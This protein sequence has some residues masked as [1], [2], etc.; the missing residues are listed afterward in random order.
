MAAR[1]AGAV[2]LA[3]LPVLGLALWRRRWFCRFACPAGF[4]Q[5]LLSGRRA[6]S[7]RRWPPIGAWIL[8]IT[9]GGAAF[10]YPIFLWLDP[11]AIFSGFLNAWRPPLALS[12]A[13]LLPAILAFNALLPGVWC[14]RICPLG[15]AQD[16]LALGWRFRRRPMDAHAGPRLARRAFFGVCAGGAGA[17]LTRRAAGTPPL[18]P[19]GAL[20]EDRFRGVCVRCGNCAAACPPRIIRPD[21]TNLTGFLAPSLDFA[22]DYCWETCNACGRACPSG[23]IARMPLAQKRAWSIGVAAV[24]IVTC[25]LANGQECTAC[26][27]A[28]PN[29]AIAV[30]AAEDGFESRPQVDVDRCN[31]C[32]ACEAACTRIWSRSSI[33]VLMATDDRPRRQG[34]S[35]SSLR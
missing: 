21:L 25:A 19:P 8:A 12:A 4:L 26:I 31:G 27:R 11:L 14:R 17:M 3:G 32:G 33:R 10:G 29:E 30:T 18:R 5:D 22:R 1:T 7:W 23:A 34:P 15:V 24:D 28:C 16:G 6:A 35:G 9:L 20:S 2:A 13:V